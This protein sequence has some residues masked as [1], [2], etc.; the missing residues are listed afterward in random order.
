MKK[1]CRMKQL[2]AFR[3]EY[4]LSSL[5]T[6]F[7]SKPFYSSVLQNKYRLLF[8]LP[9]RSLLAFVFRHFSSSFL[10]K[11]SHFPSFLYPFVPCSIFFSHKLFFFFYSLFFLNFDHWHSFLEDF[12][13]NFFLCSLYSFFLRR[14]PRGFGNSTKGKKKIENIKFTLSMTILKFLFLMFARYPFSL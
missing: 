9:I 12:F 2:V 4:A 6:F 10:P 14:L 3:D 1:Q 13:F 7:L 8:P 5:H 11:Y